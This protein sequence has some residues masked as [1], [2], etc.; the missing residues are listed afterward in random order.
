MVGL[1][2]LALALR[3]WFVLSVGQTTTKNLN[4]PAI[5]HAIA[6]NL[7]QGR[8]F[9]GIQDQLTA[10]FPPAYSF[11][12]SLVYRIFGTS[13]TGGEV[14]NAFLGAATVP[15]LFYATRRTL[16]RREAIFVGVGMTVLLGQIFWTDVL[17]G[18]TL[19]T[20]LVA[21]VLVLVTVLAPD[22]RRSA[23][24]L[25]IVLGIATLTRGEG[26]F[27]IVLPLAMWWSE[28][29]RRAL[30]RQGAIMLLVAAACVVPWTIRNAVEMHAFI[31]VSTNFGSTF[32]SGHNPHAYGGPDYAPASL[33]DKVKAP[34][35][36]PKHE[37]ELNSLL[38][39]RAL[40]WMVSHPLDELRLIPLKL[41]AFTGGDGQA[42]PLWIDKSAAPGHPVLSADAQ[43]RLGI[44]ADLGSYTVIVLFVASLFVFGKAL[45]Q[46]R[47]I[48]RGSLAYIAVSLVLYGFVFYGN[49]RYRAA[50]EP[51]MLMVAAPLIAQL[52]RLRAQR[53]A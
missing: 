48:L 10:Q 45:W 49:F 16:G 46:R 21:V 15:L 38:T 12:L 40:S 28:M 5:Y 24:L 43:Y 8:G 51:L 42:I 31:P 6:V 2:L 29:P 30:R 4:D 20:F 36:S 27:L 50:L 26:I 25:G 33:L 23:V 14:L 52:I 37:L 32:W 47:P 17:F 35:T 3:L 18:E 41:I 11:L 13:P 22:R 9:R 39:H 44:L 53:F 34:T 1:G 7:A 19:F